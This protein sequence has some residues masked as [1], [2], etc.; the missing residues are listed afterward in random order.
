MFI[1]PSM[2]EHNNIITIK[3]IHGV[4]SKTK[5]HLLYIINTIT[6]GVVRILHNYSLGREPR[7]APLLVG[8]FS[9]WPLSILKSG[10]LVKMVQVIFQ[11][12]LFIQ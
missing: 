7:E 5:N 3:I 1:I 12:G 6:K 4:Y 2:T 8:V 9:I 11:G 10:I